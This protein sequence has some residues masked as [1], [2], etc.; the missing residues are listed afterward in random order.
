MSDKTIFVEFEAA[1]REYM[2]KDRYDYAGGDGD[3]KEFARFG[4][5][6]GQ[7]E[8]QAELADLRL[9]FDG[10]AE[11]LRSLDQRWTHHADAICTACEALAEYDRQVE[12]KIDE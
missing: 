7:R 3:L 5:E 9:V 8:A 10:M 6:Y 2:G 12:V 4:R 11:E 1:L